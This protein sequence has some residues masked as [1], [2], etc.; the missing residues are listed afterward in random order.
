VLKCEEQETATEAARKSDDAADDP[1]GH[2][3]PGRPSSAVTNPDIYFDNP[4]VDGVSALSESD[5][6]EL[7]EFG[8]LKFPSSPVPDPGHFAGFAVSSSLRA[9]KS[10]PGVTSKGL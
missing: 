2:V 7:G 1:C 3:L 9:N 8:H 6:S 5:A 4:H 10:E